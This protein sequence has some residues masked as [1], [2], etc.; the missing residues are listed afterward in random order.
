MYL[1]TTAEMFNRLSVQVKDRLSG[2]ILPK[3]Q[4]LFANLCQIS[5]FP[6]AQILL[7]RTLFDHCRVSPINASLVL[8]IE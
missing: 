4:A 7:Q 1:L 3:S 8:D 5:S 6:K 2:D